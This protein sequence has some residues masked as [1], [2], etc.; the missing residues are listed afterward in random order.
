ML[1]CARNDA[2]GASRTFVLQLSNSPAPVRRHASSP[3]VYR[4]Q[5][6]PLQFHG[7]SL[8]NRH[9]KS[10]PQYAPERACGTLGRCG[11]PQPDVHLRT[12]EDFRTGAQSSSRL[13]S[14]RAGLTGCN[15][16]RRRGA[17]VLTEC[18]H[19]PH[20][21]ILGPSALGCRTSPLN[22]YARCALA[23]DEG[24]STAATVPSHPAPPPD[25]RESAL[26]PAR[27]AMTIVVLW[28]ESREQRGA[29]ERKV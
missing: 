11:C 8:R 28:E 2:E 5:G 15:S 19:R 24:I 22:G 12:P 10:L 20:C 6:S 14:A 27:D 13:R 4:L 16:Q 9:A 17:G 23:P 26:S 1:R 7:L 21:W 29:P 3:Q 18:A 25:V